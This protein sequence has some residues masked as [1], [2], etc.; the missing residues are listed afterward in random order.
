MWAY[1]ETQGEGSCMC[2]MMSSVLSMINDV[3]AVLSDAG[4]HAVRAVGEAV[5]D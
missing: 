5:T 2:V 1:L 3:V 4:Y